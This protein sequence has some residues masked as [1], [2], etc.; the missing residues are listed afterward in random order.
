MKAELAQCWQRIKKLSSDIPRSK[1][2]LPHSTFHTEGTVFKNIHFF[3]SH[4]RM[5]TWLSSMVSYE[6]KCEHNVSIPRNNWYYYLLCWKH[7][8]TNG[9]K[10][11]FILS[12]MTSNRI[13]FFATLWVYNKKEIQL[14]IF[15]ES[16]DF[17]KYN[18][19]ISQHLQITHKQSTALGQILKL[20]TSARQ[21]K[22]RTQRQLNQHQM[23]I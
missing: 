19:I 23:G 17:C 6:A 21:N 14:K 5:Q 9:L 2:N 13:F 1:Q 15:R 16:S 12:T 7:C 11:I 3:V 22:L 18:T 10:N 20:E 8:I 4:Y